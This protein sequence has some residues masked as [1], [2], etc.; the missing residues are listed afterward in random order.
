MIGNPLLTNLGTIKI[1]QLP[2][3]IANQSIDLEIK[4]SHLLK[5]TTF[6]IQSISKFA[7]L[8]KS[9]KLSTQT[10]IVIPQCSYQTSKVK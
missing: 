2:T 10:R 4:S 6:I 1:Q 8:R 9:L 7:D 3:K 5:G